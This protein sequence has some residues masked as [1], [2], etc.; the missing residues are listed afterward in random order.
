M[1]GFT[2]GAIRLGWLGD[3]GK[4]SRHFAQWESSLIAHRQMSKWTHDMA[5]INKPTAKQEAFCLA[6]ID[7][8]IPDATAAY[9][10]AYD[11]S[12]MKP[13]TVNR[14]AK[15]LMDNP[16]IATRIA[17]LRAP[18]LK[19]LNITLENVLC[20]LARVAFANIGDFL[21][22]GENGKA[23]TTLDGIAPEQLTAI[24][25]VKTTEVLNG[26][27]DVVGY[28]NE[29]E[30]GDKLRALEMLGRHVGAFP[31]A[32]DKRDTNVTINQ[33]VSVTRIELARRMA[34]I[35]EDGF[36]ATESS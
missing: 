35:I 8:N 36:L 7:P 33:E 13:A 9:R 3:G 29:F 20:E 11:C 15:Q 14:A 16:K 5:K 23:T 28:N 1:L 34:F 25:K 24:K 12:K 26:D 6:V 31:N 17:E 18:A 32:R 21:E 4:R 2:T 27:G 22:I 10:S 30:L 19:K